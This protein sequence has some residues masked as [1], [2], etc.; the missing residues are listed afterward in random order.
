MSEQSPQSD[1]VWS[2][3]TTMCKHWVDVSASLEDI[4]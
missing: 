4:P 2:V 3:Q 1:V